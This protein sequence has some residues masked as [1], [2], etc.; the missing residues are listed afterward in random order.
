MSS[1]TF[2]PSD[3]SLVFSAALVTASCSLFKRYSR[4]P[5]AF[6][7]YKSA[8]PPFFRPFDGL[9][10]T[11]SD[12]D[13][14]LTLCEDYFE[15]LWSLAYPFLLLFLSSLSST[16]SCIGSKFLDVSLLFACLFCLS[17]TIARIEGSF[18]TLVKFYF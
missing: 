10:L 8:V 11:I 15:R 7:V 16:L 3:L 2:D 13:N 1:F 12:E 9:Y 4:E 5:V 17:A 14:L 18:G 6:Y